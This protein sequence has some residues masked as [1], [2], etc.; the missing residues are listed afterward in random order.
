MREYPLQIKVIR[1]QRKSQHICLT[2]Y[3]SLPA[4]LELHFLMRWQKKASAAPAGTIPTNLCELCE[5]CEK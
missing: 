5:L 1:E 3:V 2:V 4:P